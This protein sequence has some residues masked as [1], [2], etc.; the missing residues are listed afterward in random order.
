MPLGETTHFYLY[1]RLR[2]DEDAELARNRV[3]TMQAA[4]EAQT[5]IAGRLMQRADDATTWMEIY[6]GVSDRAGFAAALEAMT[7]AHRLGEMLEPGGRRHTECFLEN[8]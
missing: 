7:L 1:Y 4:L 5:G 3:R 6:E 2:A 8:P